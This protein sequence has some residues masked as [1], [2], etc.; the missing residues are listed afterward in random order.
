MTGKRNTVQI[1][2][3]PILFIWQLPQNLVTLGILL[4]SKEIGKIGFHP[5]CLVLKAKLPKGA[6]GISLGNFAI[7]SP[8]CAHDERTIR[9]EA[10][11]HTVDS[12]IFGPLYL[13]VIGLPSALHLVW[14]NR[15]GDRTNY[16]DFYTERWADRHAGLR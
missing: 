1:I 5:Y 13:L 16:H 9:H 11:G 15:H 8:D 12:M 7:V 3:F 4:F 10:D 14:Y 6:G 2:F